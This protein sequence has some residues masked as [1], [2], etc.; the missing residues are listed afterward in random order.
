M[1]SFFVPTWRDR[2][3][4]TERASHIYHTF[5]RVE[6]IY[7]VYYFLGNDFGPKQSDLKK[8]RSSTMHITR[9]RLAMALTLGMA[10]CAPLAAAKAA[11]LEEIK[12]RGQ[13]RIA[14]ANEIP[15]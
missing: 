5:V 2:H 10:L 15:Y 1:P 7:S 8:P 3:M 6:T 4:L 9:S 13:I 14:V 12:Q 11:S